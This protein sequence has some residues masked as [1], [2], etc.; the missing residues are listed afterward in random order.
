MKK[1]SLTKKHRD[2]FPFW[3]KKWIDNAMSCEPMNDEDRRICIESVKGLYS[4]AKLEPPKN[5]VFVSSPF[6]LRF[7]SGF[8]SWIWWLRKNKVTNVATYAA[9]RVAI[10]DATRA[11][12]RAAT[13]AATRV[14][15]YA[16]T[17]DA[18]NAATDAAT[19]AATDAATDAATYAATY[20][21][22]NNNASLWYFFKEDIFT[23]LTKLGIGIGGLLCA[24]R[25]ISCWQGGNQWS[26][27]DCFL[28]FFRHIAKLPIDYSSWDHWEKLSFHSGPRIVHKDFCM[29]SDRPAI[30]KVDSN[31]KP[32]CE[33]GPFC[34]WRDGSALFAWHGTHVPAKLILSPQSVT[35]KELTE[36]K[37]SEVSRA[38]FER[39]GAKEYFK[40]VG[41]KKI[42][43]W[44]DT[45]TGLHY[46]LYD[47]SKRVGD[48]QP[49]MLKMES[50]V[51]KDGTQPV[52]I[53]PVDPGLLTAKAARRWQFMKN[54]CTWPTV[55]ECNRNPDLEFSWEA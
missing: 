55:V 13:D 43:A 14:A 44:L 53:E 26:A 21:A 41:V 6:T 36:E 5:I 51:L 33:E 3:R 49:K 38:W 11:A 8:A 9:T 47:F 48:L 16:A 15:T 29:I 7:A 31:N 12:T 45:K 25:I 18:T 22:T 10:D 23:C 54:D 34:V 17:Y 42:D 1:Y 24:Q 39:L 27:Y 20:A 50:P 35:Q 40:K 4:A 52:Y 32:H 28:S 46:E 37:N 19:N 2:Q 30:L